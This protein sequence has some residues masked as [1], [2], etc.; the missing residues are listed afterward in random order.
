MSENAISTSRRDFIK[1]SLLAAGALG[2]TSTYQ[3]KAAAAPKAPLRLGGP[4]F[5]KYT[6]PDEWVNALKKL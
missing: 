6:D 5:E 2:W 1:S 4:V 3:T